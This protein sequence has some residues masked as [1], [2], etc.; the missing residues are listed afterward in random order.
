MHNYVKPYVDKII[1]KHDET[2]VFKIAKSMGIKVILRNLGGCMGMTVKKGRSRVI[3]I[4]EQVTSEKQEFICAHELAHIILHPNTNMS[5]LR[6][7]TLFSVD[8][9]E[10]EANFFA[11]ELIFGRREYISKTELIVDYGF[12]AELLKDF[13][14]ERAMG[15]SGFWGQGG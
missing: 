3:F 5:F 2:N 14:G 8:Q 7:Y 13:M 11:F 12:E 10:R 6:N 15:Q 4:N 9:K 1:K